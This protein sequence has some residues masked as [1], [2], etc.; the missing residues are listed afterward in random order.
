MSDIKTLKKRL[1]DPLK[2]ILGASGYELRRLDPHI[3]DGTVERI[4]FD[5]VLDLYFSL[6]DPADFFF[7]QIGANDGRMQ[8]P[9][10]ERIRRYKLK[11]LL[12]EPQPPTFEDLKKNYADQPQLL[13]EN[14][15]IATEPGTLTLYTY[16]ND[17]QFP[18]VDMNLSG[19]A[20]FDRDHVLSGFRRFGKYLGLKGK[21]EDHIIEL[22]VQAITF[23]DLLTRHKIERFD[24]L[25]IDTEGYDFEILKMVDFSRHAPQIV[26]FEYGCMSVETRAR[27]WGY[28]K[29]QGYKCFADGLDALCMR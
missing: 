27:A 28:M 14:V 15:A 20:S 5:D 1:K 19:F 4:G 25:Q 22:P 2:G 8:D 7:I 9:L 18:D 29:K 23:D 6:I 17:Y 24:Y 21:A 26:R 16:P 11:G 10:F 3:H 12:V 13:F